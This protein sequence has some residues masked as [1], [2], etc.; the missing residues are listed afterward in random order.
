MQGERKKRIADS[1]EQIA[2]GEEKRK[3]N[4]GTQRTQRIRREE[5][6]KN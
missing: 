1:S 5:R 4:A 6:E 2:G 3:D